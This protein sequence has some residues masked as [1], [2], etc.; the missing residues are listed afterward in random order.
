MAS[1]DKQARMASTL[2]DPRCI[3]VIARDTAADGSFVYS[4]AS[5]G[6]FCRPTC[7]SRQP[8]VE[9]VAFH[10]SATEAEAAGFA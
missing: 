6:V 10:A 8:R 1:A 7:P 4:V 2:A 5:A 9:Q 3:A